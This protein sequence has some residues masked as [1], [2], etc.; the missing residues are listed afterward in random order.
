MK[1]FEQKTQLKFLKPQLPLSLLSH[2]KYKILQTQVERG[3]Y[4]QKYTNTK[5][6]AHL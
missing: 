6:H 3:R 1:D 5:P 2:V 4:N